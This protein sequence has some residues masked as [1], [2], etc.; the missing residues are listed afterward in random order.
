M[1]LITHNCIICAEEFSSDELHSVKLSNINVTK[2][3]ICESCLN[4]SD[5]SNDYQEVKNIVRTYIEYSDIR[6]LYY[7]NDIR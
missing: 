3:K 7:N 4:K 6:K 5:P 1:D 2:F